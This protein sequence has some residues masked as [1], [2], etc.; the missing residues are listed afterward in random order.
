MHGS[1][2]GDLT[3]IILTQEDY[4]TFSFK[5]PVLAQKLRD[6]LIN[7]CILFLGYSYSDPNIR[8]VMIEAMKQV[9]NMTHEYYIIIPNI[10]KM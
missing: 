3:N 8:T 10:K 7:R 4:D 5:K 6:A 1:A 9:E 2:E